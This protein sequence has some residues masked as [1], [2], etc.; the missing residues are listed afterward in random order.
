MAGLTPYKPGQ[1]YW[2]R[3]MSAI[4]FGAVAAYAAQWAYLESASWFDS[5]SSE[6]LGLYQ[7][8]SALLV[9]LIAAFFIYWLIYLKPKTS[10]FLIATEGEMRKVN[11]STRKEIIGS[12]WVVIAISAIIAII[13][14]VTD[15][16]FSMLFKLIGVLEGSA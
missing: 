7:G 12:T 11:W 9:V 4:G 2:T 5:V 16:S 6:Q 8:G 14:L 3:I 10:E 13:L 15:I 1:G